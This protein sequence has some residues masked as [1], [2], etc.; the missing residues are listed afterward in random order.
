MKTPAFMERLSEK[1][2]RLF[3]EP[4]I[5]DRD[6]EILSEHDQC[7]HVLFLLSG[8]IEVYK[9]SENGKVFRLYTIKAGEACVLNLSCVLSNNN[10]PAYAR[11]LTEIE[12]VLLPTEL[13]LDV[14]QAEEALR[15]FVF[16]LISARLIQITAKVEG[17]VLE[18]LE[19]RLRNWLLE[20]QQGII[21]VTHEEL[22]NQL[23]SVREVVS[24]QLKKWEKEG[25]V[26]LYRGRIE[27]LDL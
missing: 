7:T 1:N 16:E 21:P 8:E 4:I 20:R 27:I 14:F 10:Y 19:T 6:F 24:R 13:F 18:S 22:A 5:L 23:G 11:A 26:R 15:S 9:L 25:K 2:R 17:I 12:C 3:A